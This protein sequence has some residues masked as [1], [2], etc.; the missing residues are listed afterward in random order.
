MSKNK[1]LQYKKKNSNLNPI[2]R[3]ILIILCV[4]GL[5]LAVGT[6]LYLRYVQKNVASLLT[7]PIPVNTNYS[8]SGQY[9]IRYNDSKDYIELV[10]PQRPE[11][12]A[13]NPKIQS[14]SEFNRKNIGWSKTEDRVVITYVIQPG[15]EETRQAVMQ[16][17]STDT[18]N[19]IKNVSLGKNSFYGV[20]KDTAFSPKVSPDGK[21]IAIQSDLIQSFSIFDWNG[22][23]V[24]K[25][26]TDF[27]SVDL[28][29][30]KM[31]T[32]DNGSYSPFLDYEWSSD[33]KSLVYKFMQGSV[34]HKL[35]L[36]KFVK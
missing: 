34:E 16:I 33:G 23:L 3:I 14:G 13:I 35:N 19:L 27:N 9:F 26:S 29:S 2:I 28:F 5:I 11:Q 1:P 24:A 12:L 20:N 25:Q 21:Y 7:A 6:P 36:L 18:G 8:P 15:S 4:V 17:Y 30:D 32:L 10:T 31:Y 22:K